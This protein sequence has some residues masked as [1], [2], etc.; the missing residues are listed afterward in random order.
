VQLQRAVRK[1]EPAVFLGWAPHPM[2]TQ[3]DITY[4]EG[5][6]EVFGPDY[7]AAKV[8]TVVPPDYEARCA[9]VGKLLN[10]LQFTVEIESQLMEKVLE[11]QNP[12]TV[13]AEWIKA[14][15]AILEQWLAGVTT[16]DGQDG[17]AAVKK[18][19]GM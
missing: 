6:D 15:P 19:L 13:A 16:Y 1:N 3:F 5:G 8:Y 11:K 9:N 7:G 12:T 4:L 14:N 18:H 10:N 17:I 2:N